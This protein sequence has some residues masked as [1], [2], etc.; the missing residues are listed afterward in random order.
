ML[1]QQWNLCTDC[2]SAQ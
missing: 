1:S 2:K